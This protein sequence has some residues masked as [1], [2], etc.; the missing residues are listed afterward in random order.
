MVCFEKYG[1]TI[2]YAKNNKI[3]LALLDIKLNEYDG[4]I[5]A[6]E[7]KKMN[8]YIQVCF[9]SGYSEDAINAFKLEAIGFIEKPYNYDEV[10]K[11]V[12]LCIFE[13]KNRLLLGR[14][15]VPRYIF[16]KKTDF[17]LGTSLLP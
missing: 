14:N 5:L 6:E 9:V 7:L 8:P 1:E 3:D 12:K 11:L 16:Q 17:L 15:R 2:E 13:L 10:C 4:Y